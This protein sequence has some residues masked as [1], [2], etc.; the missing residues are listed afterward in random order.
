VSGA[1][2]EGPLYPNKETFAGPHRNDADAPKAGFGNDHLELV[3]LVEVRSG[4]GA[5]SLLDQEA[6][7]VQRIV[8]RRLSS[9]G[10][11]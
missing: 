6:H 3:G 11:V 5:R 9:G 8:V 4:D 1:H 7:R 10:K 2:A